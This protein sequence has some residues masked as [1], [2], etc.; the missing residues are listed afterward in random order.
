MTT[1]EHSPSTSPGVLGG[2]LVHCGPLSLLGASFVLVAGALAIR[3]L[4]TAVA[5]MA[6][7]A[8]VLPLVVGRSAFPLWRLAPAVFAVASVAWSNWLLASPRTLEPAVVAA[9]R[10]GFFVVPGLVFASYLDPFTVGDHLGQ[11]LRLPG[12][13]VL[14]FVAALQ[15]FDAFAGDWQVLRQV[16]RVRGLSPARGLVARGRAYGALLFTLLVDA[17]RQAGRMTAAMEARGYS[18]PTR[19][20]IARTWLCPA[21]WTAADSALMLIAVLVALVVAWVVTGWAAGDR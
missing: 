5:A 10:V 16:R 21:P 1:L 19:T 15:R 6:A 2:L 7:L 11:R 18:A 3:D 8:V 20:G 14:A 9:L 17:I 13:P 4:R 12:R